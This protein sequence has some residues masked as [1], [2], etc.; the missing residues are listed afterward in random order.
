MAPPWPRHSAAFEAKPVT[1]SLLF[2]SFH[3]PSL[4]LPA[5]PLPPCICSCTSSSH[6]CASVHPHPPPPKHTLSTCFIFAAVAVLAGTLQCLGLIRHCSRNEETH[7][8]YPFRSLTDSPLTHSISSS[9][10]FIC[11]YASTR[12]NIHTRIKP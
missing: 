5:C 7:L 3:T 10:A 8:N 1:A 4:S 11:T 2:L 12:M 6:L 9:E